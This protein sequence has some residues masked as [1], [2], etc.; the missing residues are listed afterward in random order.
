MTDLER[1]LS[2]ALRESGENYEPSDQAEARRRF[3]DR[4][5]RRRWYGFAQV[6]AV[7]G[8]GIAAF[9]FFTS[10]SGTEEKVKP[11]PEQVAG[12]PQIV[13][14]VEIGGE[15]VSIDGAVGSQVWVAGKDRVVAVD[16]DTNE[17]GAMM[18][19]VGADEVAVGDDSL[20]LASDGATG[21]IHEVDLD[22]LEVVDG[23]RSISL[24]AEPGTE[25]TWDIATDGETLWSVDGLSDRVYMSGSRSGEFAIPGFTFTDVAVEQDGDVWALDQDA[26]ALVHVDAETREPIGG[27]VEVPAGENADLVAGFQYVYVSPGDGS[28]YQIT[29]P[30]T[31]DMVEADLGASYMDLT[32]H[33]KSVW[34][35]VN[36]EDEPK[37]LFEINPGTMEVIGE[38]LEIEG[39]AKDVVAAAGSVWVADGRGEVL[40]IE[41]SRDADNAP[42]PAEDDGTEVEPS[43]APS[44]DQ[45]AFVYSANGDIYG[46]TLH[47]E[48][49]LLNPPSGDIEQHPSF[50][51]DGQSIVFERV[52]SERY[53]D[54]DGGGDDPYIVEMDLETREEKI[55]GH[56][57]WPARAADGRTAWV[58]TDETAEGLRSGIVI[59]KPFGEQGTVTPATGELPNISHLSWSPNGKRLVYQAS[60]E[61]TVVK[62][63]EVDGVEITFENTLVPTEDTGLNESSD[64]QEGSNL[65]SPIASTEGVL[66]LRL[67]CRETEGDPFESM[68]FGRVQQQFEGVAYEDLAPMSGIRGIEPAFGVEL[69]PAG[70]LILE[71]DREDRWI[72]DPQAAS[73]FLLDDDSLWMTEFPEVDTEHIAGNHGN[74]VV[75][76]LEGHEDET[77]FRGL[78]VNPSLLTNEN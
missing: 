5:R 4:A 76:P 1:L 37:Q 58:T 2:E 33:E 42:P 17:A 20:W 7:A 59:S 29:P 11:Q 72:L 46:E 24:D 25:I 47:G 26:G 35:L 44:A 22:T 3:L 68:N 8:V 32:V 36:V 28:L 77:D 9:L 78:A 74:A 66:V 63:A 31:T 15:P 21:T 45:I 75:D 65:V 62:E 73:L 43:P 51:P 6:A 27:P 49:V 38:P 69:V 30:G 12:A 54:E 71:R 61:G 55:I 19:D 70:R 64:F 48:V 53:D 56:G 40:R 57:R 16:P 39:D 18:I 67:C 14:T 52:D 34:A 10:Q 13:A 50:A 41:P 23:A 60:G